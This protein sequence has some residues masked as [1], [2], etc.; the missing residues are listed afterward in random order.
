LSNWS[1]SSLW[2]ICSVTGALVAA[3]IVYVALYGLD[4]ASA[5]VDLVVALVSIGV[6]SLTWLALAKRETVHTVAD[7]TPKPVAPRIS[8]KA[9]GKGRNYNA[10][11]DIVIGDDE[12]KGQR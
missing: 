12:G 9:S 4:E 11:R 5:L 7:P 2:V 8:Q 3:L 1:K 6:F 10:G